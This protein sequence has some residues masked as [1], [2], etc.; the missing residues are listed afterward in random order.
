M[1]YRPITLGPIFSQLFEYLLFDKFGPFLE[2]DN[3]QFGFE[4]NHA[5][6]ALKSCVD[7]YSKH[8][9]NVLVAF[10]DCS[11]AF[12]TVSHF[13]IFLKLMERGVPLCFFKNHNVPISQSKKVDVNGAV[14]AV[15]ILTY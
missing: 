6:F 15:T 13:E 7:Y 5:V 14:H 10:M 12:D 8:G 9:S 2:S 11:K 1:V 4:R 3:L